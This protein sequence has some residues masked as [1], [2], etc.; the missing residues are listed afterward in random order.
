MLWHWMPLEALPKAEEPQSSLLRFLKPHSSYTL[1]KLATL[2]VSVCPLDYDFRCL[3][4]L[5]FVVKN[6]SALKDIFT[7]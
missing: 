5:T 4:M 6:S 7:L 2:L 1:L 3:I